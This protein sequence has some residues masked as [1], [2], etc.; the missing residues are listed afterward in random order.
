M[1]SILDPDFYLKTL[2]DIDK[3]IHKLECF[4]EE[5]CK[6][7]PINVGSGVGLFKRL[8]KGKW[9][10]KSIIPGNNI[11]ITDNGN[12][13][14]ISSTGGG[15]GSGNLTGV[16]FFANPSQTDYTIADVPSLSL[17]VGKSL[18]L[19]TDDSTVLPAANASWD[20]TTFKIIDIPIAG[21]ETIVIIA[22]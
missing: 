11:T 8:H 18:F 5:C 16:K 4:V 13:I 14:T 3:R 15:G 10:F 20:N 9:E 12:D 19:V 21:G 2:K 7:I 6:K 1:H 17:I 22:L